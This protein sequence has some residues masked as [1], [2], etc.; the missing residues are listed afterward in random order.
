[1]KSHLRIAISSLSL[2]AVSAFVL[3]GCERGLVN[4]PAHVEPAPPLPKDVL[5][6]GEIMTYAG[7]G[8]GGQNGDLVRTQA[9]LY[10]PIDVYVPK[11][12]T[13]VYIVD[14][15]NHEIRKV[16]DTTG[17]L[18]TVAGGQKLEDQTVNT[19]NHPT[20]VGVF[21]DGTLA[22]CCWHNHQIRYL[23]APLTLSILYSAGEGLSD[24]TRARQSRLELP[25]SFDWGPDST[26]YISDQG[27][28]RIRRIPADATDPDG[29]YILDGNGQRTRLTPQDRWIYTFA[30]TG[31]GGFNGDDPVPAKQAKFFNPKGTGSYPG[32]RLR[33]SPDG[34]WLYYCDTWNNRIRRI[35]LDDPQHMIYTVAGTGSP[36]TPAPAINGVDGGFGG[37]GGPALTCKLNQPTDIDFDAAGNW[38]IVD[39]EN[40]RIRKVDATTGII[41]TVAGN[42]T[43]GFSGDG[44]PA[45]A[46]QVNRPNGIG[47]DRINGLLYIADVY[48]FRIRVMKL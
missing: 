8:K 26:M 23:T 17:E 19:I 10:W 30:G 35:D 44:G 20:N 31:E 16:D 37:D 18:K 11:N 5:T 9:R 46:A 6:K 28:F 39:S 12:R 15:N 25:T 34:K 22:I 13:D 2:L 21:E 43:Q 14:W 48:N 33:V 47:I 36:I 7:D 3:A 24:N 38:Y 4:F 27:N 29:N 41:T 1:M 32:S 42:G 45:T 40:N